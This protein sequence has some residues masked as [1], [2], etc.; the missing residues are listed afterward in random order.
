M[1]TIHYFLS[2]FRFKTDALSRTRNMS[3]LVKDVGASDRLKPLSPLVLGQSAQPWNGRP[4]LA[5]ASRRD[6][7]GAAVFS[8]PRLQVHL[9]ETQ[10]QHL[11]KPETPNAAITRPRFDAAALMKTSRVLMLGALIAAR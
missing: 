8:R 9:A 11:I 1:E 4:G 3:D 7:C 5:G 6:G 2:V 10:T